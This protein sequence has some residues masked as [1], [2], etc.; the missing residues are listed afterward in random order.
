MTV[1]HQLTDL[2]YDHCRKIAS[3]HYENFPVGS[4]LVPSNKR[5]YIYSVYAFARYA[6]D[7]ADSPSLEKIEKMRQLGILENELSK[8]EHNKAE[9]YLKETE[10][11]FVALADTVKSL[12]IPLREFRELLSAFKQDSEGL[13]YETSDQ[14]IDYSDR[15]A[16][17]IGHIVLNVFG[18]HKEDAGE[19]FQMSDKICTALQ[20]TNFWQDVSE[21][22][23]INRVYIPKDYM[24]KHGYNMD[25]LNV[26]NENQNFRS[27]MKDLCEMTAGLFKQGEGLPDLTEGR[28]KYEL[29]ATLNGGRMI[30]R[31]ISDLEYR[32][33]SRRPKLSAFDKFSIILRA[34]V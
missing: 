11:I 22:L 30:L 24:E 1:K 7:I 9:S 6:D 14:L 2:A 28:L 8:I 29:K 32:V 15:S 25:E 34:F 17:P 5:K 27:M 12:D 3:E 33:L 10:L 4:I 20:L 19:M 26:K 16:N 23:K 13:F 31:K 18:Y 21:D